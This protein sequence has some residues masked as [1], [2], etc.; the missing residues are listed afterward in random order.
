M[1]QKNSI[2]IKTKFNIEFSLWN[3]IVRSLGDKENTLIPNKVQKET[4]DDK[5]INYLL[6]FKNVVIPLEVKNNEIMY[7][8][9][10]FTIKTEKQTIRDLLFAD[11]ENIG[12]DI[13]EIFDLKINEIKKN[14][15]KITEEDL[16]V[17]NLKEKLKKIILKCYQVE[18]S[19]TC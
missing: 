7:I 17:E 14:N 8:D 11:V 12:V 3:G 10:D 13:L 1:K 18:V 2:N 5:N 6:S 16:E 9:T 4:E 15:I 19:F